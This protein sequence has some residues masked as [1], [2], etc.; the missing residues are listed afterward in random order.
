MNRRI[1]EDAGFAREVAW[2]REFHSAMKNKRESRILSTFREIHTQKQKK[3]RRARQ[4][5]IAVTAASI[6][7]ILVFFW[8]L[9]S[10]VGQLLTDRKQDTPK[11]ESPEKRVP[12]RPSPSSAEQP[13]A[14]IPQVKQS[15]RTARPSPGPAAGN[16]RRDIP[17]EQFVEYD[18]G[19]Q[20]LGDEGNEA[21]AQALTLMSAGKRKE[22]LPFLETYFS[23]LNP[24]DE[25]FELQ[26]EA[27]K[28][29][30]ENLRDF[31]KAAYHFNII[32]ESEAIPLYKS[33]AGFYLAITDLARHRAI[34][35]ENRLRGLSENA[36]E[37]WKTKAAQ[38]L[39]LLETQK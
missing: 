1:R 29:C 18:K 26:M 2:M 23:D 22:A 4:R 5:M 10:D 19:I 13:A 39:E 12:A 3:V 37:P 8:Y 31:T 21:L 20:T 9:N 28:I 24:G 25:D 36:M 11:A 16:L 38:V 30:L 6:L 14:E 7:L 33:E 27:G 35:A 15:P 17:W 34:D 32:L